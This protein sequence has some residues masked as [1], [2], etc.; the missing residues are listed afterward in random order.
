MKVKQRISRYLLQGLAIALLAS[1]NVWAQ[2]EGVEW[3]SLN[4]QQQRVLKQDQ[5][6]G[7]SLGIDRQQR[8]ATGAARWAEMSGK[9]R[10]AA[11]ERFTAWRSLS[12]D[13]RADIRQSYIEFRNLPRDDQQRIRENYRRFRQ[14]TP[15]RRQQ[16]RDRFRDMTP[17][18]RQRVRDRLRDRSRQQRDTTKQHRR[19]TDG[20]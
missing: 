19:Q 6:T 5:E 9:E 20:R 7:G 18:Q 4:E 8:L 12:D 14:L 11:G 1:G 13:Q 15:E 17:E 2:E 3:D 10:A 16:M